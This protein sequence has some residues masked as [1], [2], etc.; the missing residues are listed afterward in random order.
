MNI[1]MSLLKLPFINEILA[2]KQIG[3]KIASWCKDMCR[4]LRNELKDFDQHLLITDQA[5]S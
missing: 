5:E 4:L 1:L 3:M 2:I